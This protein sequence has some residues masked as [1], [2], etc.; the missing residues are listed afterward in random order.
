MNGG[1]DVKKYG[2]LG[3][4]ILAALAVVVLLLVLTG[5]HAI[6]GLTVMRNGVAIMNVESSTAQGMEA[7][8]R[9]FSGEKIRTVTVDKD[10]IKAVVTTD[11]GGLTVTITDDA[12]ERIFVGE[13][14]DTGE[15]TATV[16]AGERYTIVIEG[17]KHRGSY[18]LT[19]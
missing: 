5:S 16:Q 17:D 3:W 6:S 15:Y 9:Y 13:H 2:R 19:W 10:E 7:R 4:L 12:G 14:M 1:I 18:A 11:N 8:Y